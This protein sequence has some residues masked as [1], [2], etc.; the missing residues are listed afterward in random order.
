MRVGP[1]EG[2]PGDLLGAEPGVHGVRVEAT[3]AAPGFQAAGSID[4]EV[5]V[6]SG[7][8]SEIE[9]PPALLPGVAQPSADSLPA[10][11]PAAGGVDAIPRHG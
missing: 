4:L 9:L 10:H 1:V 6:I 2:G 5:E 3:F 7:G 11:T 8:V